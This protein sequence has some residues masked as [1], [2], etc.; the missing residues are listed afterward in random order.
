MKNCG[1]RFHVLVS[2]RDFVE[3]V[4]VRTIL[5]RND[6]PL[7]V[8]ERILTIIQVRFRTVRHTG[9][10]VRR[11]LF[12]LHQF[13]WTNSIPRMLI[14]GLTAVALFFFFFFFLDRYSCQCLLSPN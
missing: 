7:V 12:L 5:P 9:L 14:F 13:D 11:L 3:G 4:L 8:Y 2:S 6:P 1:Y 10:N